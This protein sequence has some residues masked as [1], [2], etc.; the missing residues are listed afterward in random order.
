MKET[1]CTDSNN[2]SAP[3]DSGE[4]GPG[5]QIFQSVFPGKAKIPGALTLK[6]KGT[7]NTTGRASGLITP[8]ELCSVGAAKSSNVSVPVFFHSQWAHKGPRLES[9]EGGEEDR[10]VLGLVPGAK[11][12]P[13][14]RT[15]T[16][17]GPWLP[18]WL[19]KS[20]GFDC[21]FL[22]AMIEGGVC[23]VRPPT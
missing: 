13:H 2:S 16:R 19:F 6:G 5:G 10:K 8:S 17:W 12:L 1:G 9:W 22:A 3:G 4:W 7:S 15:H 11:G 20:L 14:T 18:G 21:E 23:L